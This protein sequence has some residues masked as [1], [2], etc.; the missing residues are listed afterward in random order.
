MYKFYIPK[1]S[2]G[3]RSIVALTEMEKQLNHKAFE[4]LK[5]MQFALF[6]NI[7]N[8]HGFINGRN[9]ISCAR[10]HIGFQYTLNMDLKDFFDSISY[11]KVTAKFPEMW[12]MEYI[13][14]EGHFA[15]GIPTSP[16]IANL[17][18]LE[19]D[20]MIIEYC[21]SNKI[22][23]TRYADDLSF[24]CNDIEVIKKARSDIKNIIEK[25]SEFKIKDAKTRIQSAGKNGYDTRM[26]VGIGVNKT[27]I[28]LNKK[29][30]DI[31]RSSIHNL[32][33]SKDKFIQKKATG[34][35]EFAKLKEAELDIS[36]INLS[37]LIE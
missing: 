7:N 24:S 11:H 9:I 21:N 16:I 22:V 28:I 14:Y 29:K 33:T 6:H 25:N 26:I 5:A 20:K 19:I 30:R 12:G 18:F 2:G 8:V 3:K 37:L 1:K 23:Y 27:S 34:Y 13:C 36:K 15:Q 35:L 31:L 17:S 4:K 32:A 10:P